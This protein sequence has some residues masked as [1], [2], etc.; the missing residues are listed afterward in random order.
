MTAEGSAGLKER[1]FGSTSMHLMRKCPCTVWVMRSNKTIR[2]H[3]FDTLGLAFGALY[4]A[5]SYYYSLEILRT[6][7]EIDGSNQN[8]V[9]L[10]PGFLWSI[11][12][13]KHFKIPGTL[14]LGIGL[15]LGIHDAVD[16]F[17]FTVKLK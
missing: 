16:D 10:T 15:R 13:K 6:T 4:P 14:R 3:H 2:P 12:G 1:L 7:T 8:T 17:A 5:L 11:P 9:Y